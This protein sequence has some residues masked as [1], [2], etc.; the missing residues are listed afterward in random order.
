MVGIS[1]V[2]CH[3]EILPGG[4]VVVP[5]RFALVAP[6]AADPRVDQ[7]DVTDADTDGVGTDLFDDPDHLV[8]HH[9]RIGDASIGKAHFA[10]ASEIVT[11]VAQMGIGVA[12]PALGHSQQHLRPFGSRRR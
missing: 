4:A 9:Q 3:A 12:H 10:P 11:A 7:P 5:S 1:A 2:P 6:S 8:A